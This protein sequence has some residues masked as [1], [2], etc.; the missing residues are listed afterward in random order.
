[1]KPISSLPMI[2]KYLF[3]LMGFVQ[4]RSIPCSCVQIR[5]WFDYRNHIC[6]VSV[7]MHYKLE[8][9]I[10]RAV[11]IFLISHFSL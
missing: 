3:F 11:L 2:Y 8:N 4:I 7:H 9:N 10:L 1:M 6:I 5:T